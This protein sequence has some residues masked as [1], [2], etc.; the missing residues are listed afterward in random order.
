MAGYLFSL[1][2][3]WHGLHFYLFNILGNT[4]LW[5]VIVELGHIKRLAKGFVMVALAAITF[6]PAITPANS[7]ANGSD[8]PTNLGVKLIDCDDLEDFTVGFSGG[9]GDFFI[10]KNLSSNPCSISANG[11]VSGNANLAGFSVEKFTVLSS[12]TFTISSG[13]VTKTVTVSAHPIFANQAPAVDNQVI[14]MSCNE[15]SSRYV[16]RVIVFA[17]VGHSFVLSN[18]SG[19]RSCEVEDPNNILT[20][21]G[22]V[23][24]NGS[25]TITITGSGVFNVKSSTVGAPT[26]TFSAIQGSSRGDVSLGTDLATNGSV[27]YS[28]V[29]HSGGVVYDA[30]VTVLETVGLRDDQ[31]EILDENLNPS[32][33]N[34]ALAPKIRMTNK[35]LGGHA[36][37]KIE[38]FVSGTT[39]R[40]NLPG[41]VV[42]IVDIDNSQFI[43]AS[44]VAS[45]EL[46]S[47][48]ITQLTAT[49]NGDKL[50]ISETADSSS[51]D[52]DQDFWAV[53]KFPAT[54][55]LVFTVGAVGVG[56]STSSSSASFGLLFSSLS[57]TNP[58]AAQVL[59]ENTS[60]AAPAASDPVVQPPGSQPSA[61][62]QVLAAT[63]IEF[64]KANWAV[65]LGAGFFLIGV[66]FVLIR[67][68]LVRTRFKN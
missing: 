42:T 56:S 29:F 65:S 49:L 11:A 21:E 53:L 57:F 41:P 43:E 66:A 36:T 22:T 20:N 13:G 30:K 58:P 2:V 24:T 14:E 26:L 4:A 48:P 3:F 33:S 64:N 28:E 47:D 27:S 1:A 59:Q 18:D 32:D 17:E 12:G 31:V 16:D 7:W 23:A 40:V 46:S 5:E 44:N 62:G 68:G 61:S 25:R 55:E 50:R 34:I 60:D 63:G 45:Y 10:L 52:S 37:I 35:S 6:S 15:G 8:S 19:S 54:S 51:S 39:T 67:I 9:V 38:F